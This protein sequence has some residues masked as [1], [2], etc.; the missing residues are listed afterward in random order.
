MQ[1]AVA[2]QRP[3]RDLERNPGQDPGQDKGVLHGI[4]L[5]AGAPPAAMQRVYARTTCFVVP[6][7]QIVLDFE[8]PTTDVL[9][10]VEGAVRVSVQTAG[11][12]HLR[13]LGDFRVGEF[14]GEM[15]AIDQAPRS[16]RVESL[17]RSR[18]CIVPAG[19]FLAAAAEVPEI[20][21]RIMRLLTTRI[22]L[23]TRSL[24]EQVALPIRLRVAAEL[25]RIARPRSDGTLVI[26]P[27]PTQE[28]LA[29]R[30]GARRETI[31]RELGALAR[32][33]LLR[34]TTAAIVLTDAAALQAAVQDC[35]DRRTD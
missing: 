16:A 21:L 29:N 11:G 35:L 20:G 8:D 6:P 27:P 9:I 1:L 26:S 24:L 33:G 23:Q 18:L 10:V 12:G 19:T 15:A 31:S 14:V 30:I 5:F 13:I 4:P 32:A 22:R 17:V 34:R 2:M 3:E 7:G 25:L 28:E